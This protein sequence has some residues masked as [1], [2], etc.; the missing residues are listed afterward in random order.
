MRI[1]KVT[2]SQAT[3]MKALYFVKCNPIFNNNYH[4]VEQEGVKS[5]KKGIQFKEDLNISL[6]VKERIANIPFIKNLA[7]NFDTFVF[8]PGITQNNIANISV[9]NERIAIL[10]A[11]RKYKKA[12]SIVVS[13]RTMNKPYYGL[14]VLER[15]EEDP[16]LNKKLQR[17]AKSPIRFL[18]EHEYF[19]S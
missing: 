13:N 18:L 16:K 3:N 9:T 5:L 12:K 1:E 17:F 4:Y 15:L 10:W 6:S 14:K 7:E 8:Y 19:E 2:P 11:N